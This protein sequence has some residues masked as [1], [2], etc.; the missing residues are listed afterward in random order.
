MILFTL[1]FSVTMIMTVTKM[2]ING[3]LLNAISFTIITITFIDIQWVE[4]LPG[5]S[6][7]KVKCSVK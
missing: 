4:V 6:E 1:D 2:K 7:K 3:I 5:C